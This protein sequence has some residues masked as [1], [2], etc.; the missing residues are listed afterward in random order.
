M[1]KIKNLI[2]KKFGS[3]D[4]F[5]EEFIKTGMD[6][7]GSGWIWLCTE[8][9]TDVKLSSM[10]NQNNPYIEKCGKPLITNNNIINYYILIK[11]WIKIF[12]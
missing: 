8:D 9:G 1:G 10:L 4:K 6:H 5:K 11:N 7:F 12:Y 3:L 2:N